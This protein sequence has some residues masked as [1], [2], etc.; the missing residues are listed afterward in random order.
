MTSEETPTG[1]WLCD[2]LVS[3]KHWFMGYESFT[4]KPEVVEW[5]CENTP[6]FVMLD[7][8]R[9]EYP[10]LLMFKTVEHAFA[11]RAF[12]SDKVEV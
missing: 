8:T 11:F 4:M 2:R 7:D 6:D 1:L 3:L 9:E 5:L 12:W 10:R